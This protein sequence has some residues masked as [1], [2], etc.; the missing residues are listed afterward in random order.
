MKCQFVPVRCVPRESSWTRQPRMIHPLREGAYVILGYGLGRNCRG[1]ANLRFSPCVGLSKQS[2]GYHGWLAVH[3]TPSFCFCDYPP[4][5]RQARGRDTSVRDASHIVQ[6]THHTRDA[7]S[8]DRIV[9]NFCSW[10]HQSDTRC[11]EVSLPCSL[12]SFFV[13]I[14]W[15]G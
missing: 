5:C 9:Q 6:G 13:Y 8:K 12:N 15:A 2:S 1:R 14:F 11:S 10:T 7:S 4:P 3:T